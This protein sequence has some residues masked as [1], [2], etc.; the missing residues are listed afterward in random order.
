[1]MIEE[2]EITLIK[3]KDS[4]GKLHH[5]I[6]DAVIAE[7]KLKGD[8]KVCPECN[9]TKVISDPYMGINAWKQTCT[10]CDSNGLV[11]KREVWV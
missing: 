5:S 7:D 10:K 9:G 3:F 6:E 4:S 11:W 8:C 2:V 1:M